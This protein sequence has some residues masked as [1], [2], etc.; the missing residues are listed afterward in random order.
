MVGN[1]CLVVEFAL[2]SSGDPAVFDN[3]ASDPL[4]VAE[5]N[6]EVLEAER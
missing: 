5:V 3:V 4:A 1:K 2:D 6:M